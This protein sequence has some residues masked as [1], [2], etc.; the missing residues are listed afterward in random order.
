MDAVG[1]A[2]GRVV[3]VL[4]L[5]DR[6]EGGREA[7]EATGARVISLVTASEIVAAMPVSSLPAG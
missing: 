7:L 1:A 4:A 6:E 2:G 3:G 5:V